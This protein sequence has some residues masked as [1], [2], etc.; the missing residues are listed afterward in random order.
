MDLLIVFSAFVK[1]TAFVRLQHNVVLTGRQRH[2]AGYN[3]HANISRRFGVYIKA[4]TQDLRF[5]VATGYNERP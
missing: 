5:Q 3:D 4:G 1:H 2:T